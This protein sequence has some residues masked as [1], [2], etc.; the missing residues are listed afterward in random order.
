M[1]FE[2]F[3]SVF[4]LICVVVGL[5]SCISKY[6]KNPKRTY[7]YLA[8][9]FIAHF[10]SDYNWTVYLL[11]MDSYP[12]GSSFMANLGWN[13]AY[14][15]LLLTAIKFR[16]EQ[17]ERRGA[18]KAFYFHPLMLWP[19]V[20]NIPLFILYIQF[21]GIINNLWQVGTTT[22][23]MIVTTGELLYYR[24]N[25][26]SKGILYSRV[27]FPY[28]AA[29]ILIYEILSYGM[30]TASCFDWE[31]AFLSPYFYC[32]ILSS[33]I[34]VFFAWALNRTY[35]EDIFIKEERDVSEI[36][37]MTALQ[38]ISTLGISM[39]CLVGYVIALKIKSK[40]PA[41]SGNIESQ[42]IGV[43]F[44]LLSTVIVFFVLFLIYVFRRIVEKRKTTISTFNRSKFNLIFM[45]FF[46]ISMMLISSIASTKKF[47][48]DYVS[49]FLEK[50]EDELL[51]TTNN[52]EN[53]LENSKAALQVMPAEDLRKFYDERMIVQVKKEIK[54]MELEDNAVGMFVNA[55]GLILAHTDE[56]LEGREL[57]EIY[58]D[59]FF[60]K[61]AAEDGKFIEAIE[62]IECT[63]YVQQISNGWLNVVI[64]NNDELF[65]DFYTM[66]LRK[67]MISIIIVC[68]VNF[69]YYLGYKNEQIY[70]KKVEKLNLQVVR[71]LAAA[72]DAKD[73]YTKGHSSRVAYYSKMIANRAGLSNAEQDDIYMMGLLHDVGK[74][75][76][77]DDVINKPARLTD[78]EFELIKKH[79]VIGNDILRT[80]KER[81]DLCV[82]ARWH[83][84]RYD[85]RG[86]PDGLAGE[87]IPV[88]A[89]IIAVADAYDAMTSTR[90]YRDVIPQDK[91]REEIEKGISTQFDPQFATVMIEMIDEDVN[92]TMHE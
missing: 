3:E 25:K 81:A 92:Y 27:L 7:L 90:S 79:P 36:R 19:L 54:K 76:V 42:K 33:A 34:M 45:I 62:D 57:T 11:V 40:M 55:D 16:K 39:L 22:L 32:E 71:A 47:Y 63:V 66:L 1:A 24:Q 73:K 77:P 85:G 43:I 5:L 69:F 72:I 91:V 84:E 70:S 2:R 64:V 59:E 28:L 60:A 4:T 48:A 58:G 88:A 52:L 13:I 14:F 29:L 78:E 68:L 74:I 41:H 49:G 10:F 37:F 89:R 75:G 17:A 67:I 53:Y 51:K 21:G 9:Y 61:L 12:V 46:T 38:T 44:F 35:E 86:Y 18:A 83:H 65:E 50:A 8:I 15:F 20:T 26:K 80:I 82:G 56:K 31:E 23:V 6:I 30:W 87:K